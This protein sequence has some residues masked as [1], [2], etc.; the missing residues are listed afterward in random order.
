MSDR[1]LEFIDSSGSQMTKLALTENVAK[2][3]AEAQARSQYI[4]ITSWSHQMRA[5]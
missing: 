4:E 2:E 3:A 1:I 5:G